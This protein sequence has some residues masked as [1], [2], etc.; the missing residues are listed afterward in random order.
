M[1]LCAPLDGA[2]GAI[3]LD[4]KCTGI[5]RCRNANNIGVA[6]KPTGVIDRVEAFDDLLAID[7]L[8]NAQRPDPRSNELDIGDQRMPVATKLSDQRPDLVGFSFEID[9]LHYSL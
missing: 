8:D 7:G 9:P 4:L 6:V 2:A 5:V 1:V 3:G